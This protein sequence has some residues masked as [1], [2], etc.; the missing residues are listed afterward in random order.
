MDSALGSA[1]PVLMTGRSRLSPL[2]TCRPSIRKSGPSRRASTNSNRL[3]PRCMPERTRSHYVQGSTISGMAVVSVSVA[4][5]RFAEQLELA[6]S[7][8]DVEITRHGKVIAVLVSPGTL[9]ARR[10]SSVWGKADE[11]A[12]L[13]NQAR[14]QPIPE[15]GLSAMRAD[16]LVSGLREERSR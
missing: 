11:I 3:A 6:E 1:L 9:R 2:W 15:V 14:S 4:R 12:E 16:E 7:G 13:L 8:E 10:S 5:Q